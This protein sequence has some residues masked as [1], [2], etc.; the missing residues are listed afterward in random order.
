MKGLGAR[1]RWGLP[2]SLGVI[3][4]ISLDLWAGGE[5]WGL[6]LL[7]LLFGTG[8]LLEGIK[9]GT[10]RVSDR[11]LGVL[12]FGGTFLLW[13]VPTY[14]SALGFED[15]IPLAWM[16]GL[17]L[18]LAPVITEAVPSIPKARWRGALH[19]LLVSQWL[20][21][22]VLACVM[23]SEDPL[24]AHLFLCALIMIKG[25]DTGAYLI[26]RPFGKTPLHPVSPRK[27]VEGLLGAIGAACLLGVA[28]SLILQ[29]ETFP[30]SQAIFFGILAAVAGQL[31][32]LQESAF[33]RATGAK[34]SGETIPGLGGMLDMMDSLILAIPLIVWL[35]TL[36][37][38]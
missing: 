24:G 14:R 17:P 11:V 12:L 35:R 38:G 15:G 28:Y 23:V 10:P 20:V 5:G 6:T 19:A 21:T 25:S 26:G 18:F 27:T 3:L 8:A 30:V 2:I 33:K 37:H 34:N 7:A 1:L 4:V 32:D 31:T 13:S 22:P 16:L 9:L 29:H 36:L